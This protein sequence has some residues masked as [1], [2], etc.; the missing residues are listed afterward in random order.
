MKIPSYDKRIDDYISTLPLWQ[1]HIF[2][3]IRQLIHDAEPE[4]IE[5]IK[6]T[7]LPYFTLEGNVCALLGTKDHINVFIYDPIAPD[8]EHIVNQ[9]KDNA[10]ARAIQ[11]YQE[12]TLH[13]KAFIQLIKA[14]V[15]NNRSGGWRHIQKNK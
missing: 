8:P 2:K 1:Q 15:S 12:D 6:R 10:T 5:T 7:N 13:E 4:I 14:V 11:I 3:R 9:G